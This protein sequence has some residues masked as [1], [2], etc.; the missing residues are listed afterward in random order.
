VD[1][2]WRGRVLADLAFLMRDDRPSDGRV[3]ETPKRAD[4]SEWSRPLQ[5]DRAQNEPPCLPKM[6]LDEAA[7]QLKQ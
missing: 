4:T 6:P 2:A 7:Q 1:L 5:C 3:T